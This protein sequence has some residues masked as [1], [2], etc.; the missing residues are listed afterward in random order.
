MGIVDPEIRTH[1]PSGEA[2]VALSR[3][4]L[5]FANG[6]DVIKEVVEQVGAEGAACAVEV[7]SAFMMVNRLIEMTGQ[8]TRKWEAERIGSIVTEL[9][10]SE[11]PHAGHRERIGLV[12][13]AKRRLHV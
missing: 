3:K 10:L 6:A 4:G 13:R 1:V 9:G 7:T 8:P 5:S 12:T 2:L 11:F